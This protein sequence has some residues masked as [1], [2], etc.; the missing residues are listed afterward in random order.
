V[1]TVDGNAP[2]AAAV[3][4]QHVRERGEVQRPGPE[5]A[6]RVR[7]RQLLVDRVQTA[8]RGCRRSTDHGREAA[9]YAPVRVDG[10]EMRIAID[11]DAPARRAQADE[12]FAD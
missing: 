1:A 8:R 3:I 2:R 7:L 12:I 5:E 6:L 4:E 11:R 9:E 10:H